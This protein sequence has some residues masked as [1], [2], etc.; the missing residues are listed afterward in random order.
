M[1]SSQLSHRRG[2]LFAGNPLDSEMPGRCA[3]LRG[4]SGY[5]ARRDYISN[6]IQMRGRIFSSVLAEAINSQ[7]L[8]GQLLHEAVRC[9]VLLGQKSKT[10]ILVKH[11]LSRCG[12]SLY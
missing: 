9:K 7:N 11:F 6:Q 12:G 3:N 2:G 8:A 10:E 4:L 1:A 5:P